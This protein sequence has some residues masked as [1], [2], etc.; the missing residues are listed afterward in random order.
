MVLLQRTGRELVSDEHKEQSFFL[1]CGLAE[2]SGLHVMGT[3]L[4]ELTPLIPLIPLDILV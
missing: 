1:S 3:G 2:G 4:T